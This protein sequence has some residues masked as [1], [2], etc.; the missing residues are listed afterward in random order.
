MRTSAQGASVVGRVAHI[1]RAVADREPVG[2][3]LI[4][5]ATITG[6]PRPTA[7]RILAELIDTGMIE[8]RTGRRYGLGPAAYGLGVVA[9][10]PFGS[11]VEHIAAI[12]E[13]LADRSTVT[14]Y[15][16]ALI[17]RRVHYL[18][19]SQ[20]SSP[21]HVHTVGVG[22]TKPLPAT[23]AGIALMS[24]MPNSMQEQIM[25]DARDERARRVTDIPAL[26]D[27]DRIRSAMHA[28]SMAG[29]FC[30][31]DLTIEG[32]CGMAVL[33]PLPSDRPRMA[34]TLAAVGDQLLSGRSSQYSDMLTEAAHAVG[35]AVAAAVPGTRRPDD[36]PPYFGS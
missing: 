1:V 12:T 26:L 34:L 19:R 4:D 35:V 30:M 31:R 2:A 25:A 17:H 6:L 27:E 32:I 24:T 29:F 21:V 3:R 36:A 5:V 16:G 8:Q 23:H 20:G 9:P 14:A 13:Q 10:N 11:V 15:A 7:H 18:A 22:D 28:I 33:V